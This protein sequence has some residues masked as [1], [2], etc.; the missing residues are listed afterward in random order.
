MVRK[1][2]SFFDFKAQ[3]TIEYLIIVAVVIVLS[4]IVVALVLSSSNNS[5]AQLI[6]SSA[7]MSNVFGGSI[8]ASELVIDSNGNALFKLNNLSGDNVTIKKIIVGGEESAYNDLV[9]STGERMIFLADSNTNCVCQE[10]QKN[11]VCVVE[12]VYVTREGLEKKETRNLTI[13]CVNTAAPSQP[14]QVSGLGSGT[15]DD[16][17]VINSC[18]ELQRMKDNLDWHYALGGDINCAETINWNNGLGFEP[19]GSGD[20]AYCEGSVQNSDCNTSESICTSGTCTLDSC[21]N[22]FGGEDPSCG[23]YGSWCHESQSNCLVDCSGSWQLGSTPTW[24]PSTISFFGSLDGKGNNI[25][26]LYIN[27]SSS[28][29]IGL[30]GYI[31]GGAFLKNVGLVD[32]NITGRNYVGG[33]VAYFKG[34]LMDNAF[35]SSKI[36][37]TTIVGGLVGRNSSTSSLINSYNLGEIIGSGVIDKIGG[38]VGQNDGNIIES[39]N[40]GNIYTNVPNTSYRVGG[41]V[42]QNFGG[43]I[44]KS[45]S[46]CNLLINSTVSNKGVYNVGG[47]VGA[48]EGGQIKES[49]SLGNIICSLGTGGTIGGLVGNVAG[50][51]ISLT[52][53]LNSFSAVDINTPNASTV[54]GVFGC[55]SEGDYSTII[56]F[57]GNIMLRGYLVM[58]DQTLT[59]VTLQGILLEPLMLVDYLERAQG[60]VLVIH[61]QQVL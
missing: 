53:I 38:L 61:F 54:G 24:H 17:F 33:L 25:T 15:I 36:T 40:R 27:R 6:D 41:L 49:Y 50:S 28:D 35:N 29:N 51:S 22:C 57:V 46:D 11:A 20:N 43:L 16:P 48:T 26:N 52:S 18:K 19:I 42:G 59:L 5:T 56:M 58:Q 9:P 3:G 14:L 34:G 45:F 12:I 31:G 37:G 13:D 2:N 39:Y 23:G 1:K 8:S 21:V 55:S 32:S 10:N 30:F 60:G 44:E 7:Q 4:L 47:L